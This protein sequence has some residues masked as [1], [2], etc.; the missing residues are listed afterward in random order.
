MMSK[1]DFPYENEVS[2]VR[3]RGDSFASTAS[4]DEF[5]PVNSD[6]KYF[7]NRSSERKAGRSH[8][9]SDKSA[10]GDNYAID[11]EKESPGRV[12]NSN[13]FVGD[14]IYDADGN[15]GTRSPVGSPGNP[16]SAGGANFSGKFLSAEDEGNS[17]EPVPPEGDLRGN[18]VKQYSIK[19]STEA[20]VDE[21]GKV[22]DSR[23]QSLSQK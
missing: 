16:N 3:V 9:V 15:T 17:T 8:S 14:S 7:G 2:R 19:G 1:E 6:G 11:K 22:S 13:K 21:S 5:L 20:I 4:G 23:K 12:R 18:M 10:V